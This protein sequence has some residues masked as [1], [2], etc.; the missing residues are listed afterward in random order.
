MA[1]QLV[2]SEPNA[3]ADRQQTLGFK[4]LIPPP[5]PYPVN[6]GIYLLPELTAKSVFIVDVDSAV[7][8]YQ[9]NADLRLLP[10]STTKMMTALVALDQYPLEK[11]LT[12]GQLVI[13]GSKIGLLPGEQI[14][15][16]NLL[17][18]LL[19]D[20][21]ND[22]AEVLA[23]NYPG[24]ESAFVL[25]MNQKAA[26][27]KLENTHFSNPVGLDGKD[28]YSTAE[29]LGR[30][31]AVVISQPILAK[32][33]ATTEIVISDTSGTIKHNLKNTNELVGKVEGVK[34]I[35][36]GWTQNAGECLVTLVEK[37][38]HRVIIV[39]LESK[40]R[41]AETQSLINWVFGNFEWLV[42]APT[43]YQ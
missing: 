11:V 5:K 39:V 33:V 37:G 38:G 21:A 19:V 43:S 26:D 25:A 6:K 23:Q 13:D 10:A 14:T 12:V 31:A 28:H 18:A 29:D 3:S 22:A 35:K 42:I 7:V 41:F 9:K 2:K 8:L 32:I 24:G 15:V 27:L 36:T 20:S 40:S 16:E 30:L 1:S 34:G 4:E 17:Y